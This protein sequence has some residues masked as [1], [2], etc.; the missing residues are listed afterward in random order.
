V[1]NW[2]LV[3]ML[4]LDAKF[5]DNKVFDAESTAWKILFHLFM[6]IRQLGRSGVAVY[7]TYYDCI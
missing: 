1:N 3:F 2:I 5:K 7:I 6:A 4:N